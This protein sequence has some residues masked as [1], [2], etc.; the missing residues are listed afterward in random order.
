M[1]YILL[2]P[3][4]LKEEAIIWHL[5]DASSFSDNEIKDIYYKINSSIPLCKK[6]NIHPKENEFKNFKSFYKGF[7]YN[8]IYNGVLFSRGQPKVNLTYYTDSENTFYYSDEKY[9]I[10]AIASIMGEIVCEECLTKLYGDSIGNIM[11]GAY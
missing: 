11:L 7:N 4:H 5:F 6:E 3:E 9:I 8:L 1:G 2:S 10:R